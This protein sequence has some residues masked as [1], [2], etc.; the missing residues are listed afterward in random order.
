MLTLEEQQKK[1]IAE[2]S[3]L[4]ITEADKGRIQIF[5]AKAKK[6]LQAEK[7]AYAAQKKSLQRGF[8]SEGASSGVGAAAPAQAGSSGHSLRS[9]LLALWHLLV[10][11][12]AV[13]RLVK[14]QKSD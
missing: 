1:F 10:R 7:D 6:G 14:A 12:L 2:K 8:I 4:T 5:M 3:L 13:L 11:L 9:A